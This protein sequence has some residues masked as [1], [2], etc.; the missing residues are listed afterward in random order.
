MTGG[1]TAVEQSDE[2]ELAES[3]VE[4]EQGGEV[5]AGDEVSLSTCS[6]TVALTN[7]K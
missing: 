6:K 2:L 4:G 3:M 1:D 7:S 5:K